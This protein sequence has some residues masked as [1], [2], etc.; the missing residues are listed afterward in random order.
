MANLTPVRELKLRNRVMDCWD[1]GLTLK[2]TVARLRRSRKFYPG[3]VDSDA[4]IAVDAVASIW[5]ELIHECGC[6]TVPKKE[7]PWYKP[8]DPSKWSEEYKQWKGVTGPGALLREIIAHERECE[9][10]RKETSNEES[11]DSNCNR[12][13]SDRNRL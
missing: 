5:R 11:H 3:Y 13:D 12:V 6:A 2:Q 9:R 7:R 1:G 8:P 4:E 10:K